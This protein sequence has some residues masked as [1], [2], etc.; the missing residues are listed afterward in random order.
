MDSKK[1]IPESLVKQTLRYL[2]KQEGQQNYPGEKTKIITIISFEHRWNLKG[3]RRQ[4]DWEGIHHTQFSCCRNYKNK[5]K[6]VQ[7]RVKFCA[8][9]HRI[10][11]YH[12]ANG[13]KARQ[14]GAIIYQVN[15]GMKFSYKK[16]DT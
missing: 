13:K 11:F 12:N 16:E 5:N 9:G 10:T 15:E 1:K 3:L 6:N 8:V 7:P 14:E 2:S 4:T